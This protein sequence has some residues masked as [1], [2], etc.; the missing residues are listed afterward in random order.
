MTKIF[1]QGLNLQLG[2]PA[3]ADLL[4]VRIPGEQYITTLMGTAMAMCRRT[5]V[6][7][8]RT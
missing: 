6:L 2:P 8:A 3:Y 1:A 5:M 7:M 4:G